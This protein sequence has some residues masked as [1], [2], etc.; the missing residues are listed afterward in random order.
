M[1][2]EASINSHTQECLQEVLQSTYEGTQ[3]LFLKDKTLGDNRFK[4]FLKM[5]ILKTLVGHLQYFV[6]QFNL[7]KVWFGTMCAFFWRW[8]GRWHSEV[9]KAFKVFTVAKGPNPPEVFNVDPFGRKEAT[10]R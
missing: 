10:H 8:V 1:C 6:W 7:R 4:V 9:P 5:H 3:M 2:W